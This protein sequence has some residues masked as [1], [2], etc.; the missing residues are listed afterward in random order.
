MARYAIRAVPILLGQQSEGNMRRLVMFSVA[1]CGLISNP[2]RLAWFYCCEA[3]L[4]LLATS[5][6]ITALSPPTTT[7]PCYTFWND[8]SHPPS[9]QY[10]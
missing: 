10:E 1:S 7:N 8:P 3:R 6:R 5:H 2:S 4:V 9:T